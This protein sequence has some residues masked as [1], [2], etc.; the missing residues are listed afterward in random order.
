M[1][2]DVCMHL[3]IC[4]YFLKKKRPWIQ[5]RE[6]R[7]IWKELEWN[8]RICMWFGL[9]NVTHKYAS[10]WASGGWI[11]N[12]C[13][14]HW[15]KTVSLT[16]GIPQL[17]VVFNVICSLVG[18]DMSIGVCLTQFMTS[19]SCCWSFMGVASDVTR[20][21]DLTEN[22]MF[23]SLTIFRHLPPLSQH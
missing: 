9:Y 15:G 12:H 21:H 20:R 23:L 1:K 22:P 8:M 14:L 16:L 7:E 2:R 19:K 10:D 3:G 17:P 18:F 6:K 11:I 13:A 4:I 5:K